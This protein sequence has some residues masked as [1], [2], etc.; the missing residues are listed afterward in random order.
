LHLVG[1]LLVEVVVKVNPV[2]AYQQETEAE[3]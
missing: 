2:A 3:Q 1:I